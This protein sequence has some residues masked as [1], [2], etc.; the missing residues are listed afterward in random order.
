[1][2]F[3]RALQKGDEL[4]GTLLVMEI[5]G[6]IIAQE[7]KTNLKERMSIFESELSLG[8]IVVKEN[9]AIRQFVA[10]KQR[11]GR[12][13]GI[14][15]EMIHLSSLEQNDESLLRL[16]L[17]ST[18]EHQGLILQLPIPPEFNLE[19]VL[20]LYPLSHDVDVLGNIAYQQFKEGTLPFLPPVV[21]AIQEVVRRKAIKLEG[22]NVLVIGE[23]RLVGAPAAVWAQKK[24]RA[25]VTIANRQTEDLALL[26]Q[27]ADVIIT[28]TGNPG[29]I[30]PEM[31]KE[32]VVLLDAGSGEMAGV[33][34]GDADP[35]CAG[36]ASFF[37]PTPGGLGPITV[38]KVFE[39]FLDLYEL[40]KKRKYK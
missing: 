22:K 9:P 1:M 28:G 30:K 19:N 16:L 14:R 35:L 18:K 36:K 13:I 33:V 4:Y 7:L 17:H 37:T 31:I 21:G 23:G 15:V 27:E 32:G 6:N 2:Y 29:F 40:K 8:I 11:F 26:T 5:D 24:E 20:N 10:L 12:E 38:A 39:N 25:N 3:T 34:M